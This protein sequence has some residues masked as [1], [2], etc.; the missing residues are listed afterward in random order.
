MLV[1]EGRRRARPTMEASDNDEAGEAAALQLMQATMVRQ[2][3][4][5]SY[6]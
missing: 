4:R 3:E 6:N 1:T 2:A 5:P